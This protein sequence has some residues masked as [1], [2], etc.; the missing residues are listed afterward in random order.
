M[1]TEKQAEEILRA[2]NHLPAEKVAEARDFVL[3]LQ[4]Q[5][6]QRKIDE[7]DVWTDED[8]RD[9]TAAALSYADHSAPTGDGE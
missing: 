9:F 2:L 4:A 3:F 5:Y 6:G 7:S 1:L 8:L